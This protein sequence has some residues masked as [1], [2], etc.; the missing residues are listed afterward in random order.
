MLLIP[1][2]KTVKKVVPLNALNLHP[3]VIIDPDHVDVI[4]HEQRNVVWYLNQH[5]ARVWR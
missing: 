3:P 5:V 1:L 4:C 2:L